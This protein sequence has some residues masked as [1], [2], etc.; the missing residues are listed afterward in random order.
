MRRLFY[1]ISL[2]LLPILSI[3]QTNVKESIEKYKHTLTFIVNGKVCMEE[4]YIVVDGELVADGVWKM[5]DSKGE[6][7][8]LIEYY[9]MGILIDRIRLI[10]G[11][12]KKY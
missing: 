11:Y 4:T 10:E 6:N 2:F 1:T 5:Y 8:Y 3:G 12:R 9:K 7:I